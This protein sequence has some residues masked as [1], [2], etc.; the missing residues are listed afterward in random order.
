MASIFNKIKSIVSGVK[1]GSGNIHNGK[2]VESNING[3][4]YQN[5]AKYENSEDIYSMD[6]NASLMNVNTEYLKKYDYWRDLGE[7]YGINK[8][9]SEKTE[10]Y[11]AD[12]SRYMGECVEQEK[13]KKRKF[14]NISEQSENTEKTTEQGESNGAVNNSSHF[15][16]DDKVGVGIDKDKKK[17][18]AEVDGTV[19]STGNAENVYDE[20]EFKR[21]KEKTEKY[22][23][24]LDEI[25]D[26]KSRMVRSY[27]N[28]LT[29]ELNYLLYK[30]FHSLKAELESLLDGHHNKST[31]LGDAEKIT[32]SDN[33][34]ENSSKE[35]SKAEKANKIVDEYEK[36]YQKVDAIRSKIKYEEEVDGYA[37][38]KTRLMIFL[39][40]VGLFF[41][42]F[43]ELAFMSE[44][45]GSALNTGSF[46]DQIGFYQSGLQN[47]I[48][49]AKKEK[50]VGY[51]LVTF[52]YYFPVMDFVKA[53]FVF[54]FSLLP[55]VF[56]FVIKIWLDQ[57]NQKEKSDKDK[58]D[59]Q[60]SEFNKETLIEHKGKK[61]KILSNVIGTVWMP[62][63]SF[64]ANDKVM[65]VFIFILV[66]YTAALGNIIGIKKYPALGFYAAFLSLG[67]MI[68]MGLLMHNLVK[69]YSRY[70]AISKRGLF[71]A[72]PIKRV[73]IK[74]GLIKTHSYSLEEA[75]D[76]EYED[77]NKLLENILKEAQ[78]QKEN[79]LR[80]DKEKIN[81]KSD[82]NIRNENN[83]EGAKRGDGNIG[84][85][86]I[87]GGIEKDKDNVAEGEVTVD[88]IY[89]NGQ[90]GNEG[91]A[92]K[93]A[94]ESGD[95]SKELID[96]EKRIDGYVK[97]CKGAFE[98][99]V[100][101]GKSI[102]V[103]GEIDKEYLEKHEIE[104]IV[105][106]KHKYEKYKNLFSD[107]ITPNQG[108]KNG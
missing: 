52:L 34:E 5:S 12:I 77:V 80:I 97:S 9:K 28:G 106:R 51:G 46:Y 14:E 20:E 49:N 86:G 30:I 73:L 45:T 19:A 104:E 8:S 83:S 59:S 33:I 16:S 93:A 32:L 78:I 69:T 29:D 21:I 55:F 15:S 63:K 71:E 94:T 40:I 36:V 89:S 87:D 74:T 72:G 48:D 92:D 105:E 95:K 96:A 13:A 22:E 23:K 56:G 60:I 53:H 2:P 24:R 65:F 31:P 79:K 18:N 38:Y 25:R 70:K 10:Q 90:K 26:L 57:I 3:Y 99:G 82:D 44:Y 85:A 41:G 81:N 67:L 58:K 102:D 103:R 7:K 76:K 68:S 100:E 47:A 66:L 61:S 35:Y 107:K 64:S 91:T 42:I 6:C 50:S 75:L 88:D 101:Y 39:M 108:E 4:Q 1:V 62:L 37:F 27:W 54:F 84:S 43:V 98:A 11:V 17:Q